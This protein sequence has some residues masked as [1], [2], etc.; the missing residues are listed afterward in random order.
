M[1]A[2][3]LAPL[4]Q[5]FYLCFGHVCCGDIETQ[6]APKST[7]FSTK[8]PACERTVAKNHLFVCCSECNKSWHI[9]CVSFAKKLSPRVIPIVVVHCQTFQTPSL[10]LILKSTTQVSLPPREV[11]M[12][13]MM[14]V[15]MT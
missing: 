15:M 12:M 1:W 13:M 8:C 10:S 14:M 9:K 6:P 2:T 4:P 7:S 5:L 3:R 11:M